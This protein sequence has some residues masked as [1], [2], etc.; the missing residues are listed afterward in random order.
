[1]HDPSMTA[2]IDMCCYDYLDLGSSKELNSSLPLSTR[3]PH[4]P[5]HHILIFLSS[6]RA[7]GVSFSF[8]TYFLT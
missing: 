8:P 2:Y 5:E 4:E 3:P 7:I 6:I 1:M